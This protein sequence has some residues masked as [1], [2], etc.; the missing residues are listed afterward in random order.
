VVRPEQLERGAGLNDESFSK[1]VREEELVAD[2]D[3]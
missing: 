3:W 2:G 1:I